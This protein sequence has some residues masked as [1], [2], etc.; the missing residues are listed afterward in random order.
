L[1]IDTNSLA[2]QLAPSVYVSPQLGEIDPVANKPIVSCNA[3]TR[4]DVTLS[5]EPDYKEVHMTCAV[6][7][8]P[9]LFKVYTLA[10]VA[11]LASALALHPKAV[12]SQ[13]VRQTFF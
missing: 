6:L 10:V 12:D 2:S 9:A 1:D 5:V 7:S 4:N 8:L 13:V 3:A 11:V